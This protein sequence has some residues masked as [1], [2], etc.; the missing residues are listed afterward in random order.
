MRR[1]IP[2]LLAAALPGIGAAAG[3]APAA[4]EAA[5]TSAWT[6]ASL[7]QALAALPP[8]DAK[9]G[10]QVHRQMFCASCHGEVGVAPTLNWA[11][12]AGQKASYTAKMLLDYQQGR[13]LE[14]EGA[15]LMR[16]VAQMMTPQ[17]IADV[18]AY[19]ASLPLPRDDGTPRPASS[20]T[21]AQAEQLVRK[22]DP[23][24]LITPCAS[25][26]GVGGQGGKLEAPAL[27]G[28]NPVYFVRT[29]LHYHGGER[30]NDVAKGMRFFAERLS[31]AEIEALAAYYADLPAARRR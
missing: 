6:S 24:R 2:S 15:R 18:A 9:R 14:T 28:Q 27:G 17:Q 31:R 21:R 5:P 8:G 29:M 19:Y 23:Q 3:A 1:T 16:D 26:H 12:L 25:C 4:H 11:H 22:G 10:E 20:V 7:R 30:H 13:R